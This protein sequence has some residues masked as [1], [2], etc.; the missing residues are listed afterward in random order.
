MSLRDELDEVRTLDG[1]LEWMQER[2]LH[3]TAMQVVTQDEFSH[4]V[5]V[6]AGSEGHA[7]FG[8]T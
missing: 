1:V 4:D 8:V 5:V 3:G 7:V 6:D 2:G